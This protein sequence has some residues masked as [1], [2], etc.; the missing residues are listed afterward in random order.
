M[1]TNR[2]VHIYVRKNNEWALAYKSSKVDYPQE[3]EKATAA[4]SGDS[5]HSGDAMNVADSKTSAD[6]TKTSVDD[7]K[8]SADNAKTR[9]DDTYDTKTKADD[10]KTKRPPKSSRLYYDETLVSFFRRLCFTKDGSLLLAPAGMVRSS[11]SE[12]NMENAVH[13]YTRSGITR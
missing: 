6:D 1:L 7:I 4:P 5:T 13:V 11:A 2:A 3:D 10:T 8:T 12:T 9:A